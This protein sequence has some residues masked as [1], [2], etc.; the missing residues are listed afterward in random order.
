[1]YN[2]INGTFNL[3]YKILNDYD[4]LAIIIL[5]KDISLKLSWFIFLVFG[6]TQKEWVL[7]FPVVFSQWNILF[8]F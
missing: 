7:S 4:L 8:S 6:L 1:M 2:L 5:N 3:F